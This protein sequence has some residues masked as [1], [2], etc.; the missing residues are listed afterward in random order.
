MNRPSTKN[1]FVLPLL[2]FVLFP[3]YANADDQKWKLFHTSRN[4]GVLSY[5][6]ENNISYLPDKHLKVWIKIV[7][8]VRTKEYRY[9]RK[10]IELN[11]YSSDDYHHKVLLLEINCLESKNIILD[12]TF[13]NKAGKIIA[14][15]N[16]INQKMREDL[17]RTGELWKKIPQNSKI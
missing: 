2:L 13:N 7:P 5:Y 15:L 11:G 6:D 1:I 4:K 12:A 3:V 16:F 17:K 14:H 10:I 8:S 9:D